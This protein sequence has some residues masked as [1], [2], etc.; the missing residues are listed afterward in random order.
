MVHHRYWSLLIG[1]LEL[2][3]VAQDCATGRY[4]SEQFAEVTV[5]TGVAFGS[6]IAVAGGAQTLYMDVYEPTGDL[7]DERPVAIVAFGGSFVAGSRT[8]VADACRMFAKMGYVAVAPDYRIG[9]FLP[10]TYSTSLAVM[11]GAHDMKACVRFLRRSV[12]E[13]GNPYGIDVDR[14]MIGGF[15]AGAISALHAG[16]LDQDSE[17]PAALASQAV[18]LGGAEGLS[19]NAGYS[20]DVLGIFSFSGAL[21]DTLWVGSGDLPLCSVHETG[22]AVV[23]YYTQEVSVFGIPTGLIASGS[24]DIHERLDHLGIDNCLLTYP[25]N[26]HLGYLDSDPEGALGFVHDF[27]AD[28]VCGEGADC[29]NVQASIGN[30]PSVHQGLSA[31]P[32][33]TRGILNVMGGISPLIVQDPSGRE[34]LRTNAVPGSTVLDLSHLSDG[35]Y[36]LRSIDPAVPVVRIVKMD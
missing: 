21:G 14:I 1:L 11:R 20:S 6:N 28:L 15:S 5:T 24:H 13:N 9:F 23:P 16:F 12:A 33:P 10:N 32:N 19:G 25:G 26:G 29:G 3:G 2:P 18:A 35:T 7:L 17:L 30:G 27:C 34:V 4:R 36:L 8:D 22:D 31:S